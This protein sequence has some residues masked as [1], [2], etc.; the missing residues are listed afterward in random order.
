MTDTRKH[1]DVFEEEV[2]MLLAI[3]I[4]NLVKKQLNPAFPKWQSIS[5]S[6]DSMVLTEFSVITAQ[7]KKEL[8][9]CE[10]L[11]LSTLAFG[12]IRLFHYGKSSLTIMNPAL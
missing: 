9:P 4:L 2:K 7:E 5:L 6:W 12:A 10:W 1:N 3:L 11:E 8:L